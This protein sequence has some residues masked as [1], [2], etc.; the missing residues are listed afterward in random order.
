LT[1]KD[2]G[3]DERAPMCGVPYHSAEIYIKKLIDNGYKVAIC[4]QLTDPKEAKG[5]VERDVIKIVTPG[6]L[7]ESS[8]LDETKNNY[9]EAVFVKNEICSVCFAD[10]S[11]G[12]VNLFT[13][14]GDDI[15]NEL[16]NEISRYNPAELLFN[17]NFL[18]IKPLQIS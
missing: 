14:T 1:G 10:I 7:T 3:L 2:C 4:E 18:T 16:I 9:I 6:T 17:D 8:L 5:I 11:T 15:Q 12:D 13:K